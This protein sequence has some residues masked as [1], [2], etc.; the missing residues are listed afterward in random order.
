MN[1]Y[2]LDFNY[3][4]RFFGFFAFNKWTNKS[5]VKHIVIK[6][7]QFLNSIKLKEPERFW[8]LKKITGKKMIVRT[9]V[10]NHAYANKNRRMHVNCPNL[11]HDT[12]CGKC[13][14]VFFSESTQSRKSQSDEHRFVKKLRLWKV[15]NSETLSG[16][17]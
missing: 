13:K 7:H 12:D 10:Q 2:F 9:H 14:A 6:Q 4:C 3:F 8:K 15:S 17:R 11:V 16:R 1:F 5:R